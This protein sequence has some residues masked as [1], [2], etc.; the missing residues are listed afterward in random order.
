[1][2]RVVSIFSERLLRSENVAIQQQPT[3]TISTVYDD[4]NGLNE[5]LNKSK[6]CCLVQI[7]PTDV[8]D[9]MIRLSAKPIS[10][11]RDVACDLTVNDYSVS[12]Q[13]AR[14]EG[15]P[16][17]YRLTDLGST[18]GT[19]VNE[20][21]IEATNLVGGEVIRFG[22]FIFKFLAADCIEAQYHATVYDA[23]T[24]DGLTQ[25]FN[26]SYLIDTLKLQIARSQ[27]CNRPLSVLMMDIDHFKKINDTYGHLV[28]DEVLKEFCVRIGQTTRSDDL[29]C[30]YGGEEFALVL[31]ETK[32]HDGVDLAE[33][34][35]E[36][37][38]NRPFSTN[39]GDLS[40]T[41]SLGVA[42][43]EP[44]TDCDSVEGL[45]QAADVQLYRA[46][47]AGRN[48][49]GWSGSSHV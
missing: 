1:M 31:G 23:M 49:V 45:L 17:G 10:V 46:K 32:L 25:S 2:T 27:R 41:V 13:H 8:V 6:D 20:Q 43:H 44:H 24:R 47:Q 36:A 35:R 14:L 38:C 26:K 40:V 4:G 37:I 19:F 34:C 12:R 15:L 33:R 5:F 9:G 39:S 29:L 22:S 3:G 21:R 28:G 18:N 42:Q 16:N 48:R 11:G 7:Y 30:R